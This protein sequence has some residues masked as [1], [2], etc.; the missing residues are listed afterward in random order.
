MTLG[1]FN[2]L[3]K[4]LPDTTLIVYP[5]YYKGRRLLEYSIDRC[6]IYNRNG[7]VAIVMAT[8]DDYD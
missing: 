8:G 1:E 3:T 4:D 2:E 5:A 6:W 7:R